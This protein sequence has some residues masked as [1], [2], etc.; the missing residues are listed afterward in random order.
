MNYLISF[1]AAD[2][3]AAAEVVRLGAAIRVAPQQNSLKRN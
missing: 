3:A 2:T 1:L